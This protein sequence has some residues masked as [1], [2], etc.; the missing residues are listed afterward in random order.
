[1]YKSISHIFKKIK[2]KN[3]A[4]FFTKVLKDSLVKSNIIKNSGKVLISTSNKNFAEESEKRFE[5]FGNVSNVRI[6]F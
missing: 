2:T 3:G 5:K 6:I 4:T 1:M